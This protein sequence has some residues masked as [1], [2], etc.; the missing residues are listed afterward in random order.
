VTGFTGVLFLLIPGG[1]VFGRGFG[2]VQG[3]LTMFASALLTGGVGPWLPFEMLC[4]AWVGFFAGCLPRAE[5]R[6]EIAMLA[7]YGAVAGL[8]YGLAMDMWFWPYAT[9]GTELHFVA[10]ASIVENLQRFWAFHLASALGFD[11]PRAAG[12]AA[13]VLVA[14]TPVL[15]ALRR[16][17]RRAAF[18]APVTFSSR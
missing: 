16:A 2:F 12:N 1:R 17:A 15:A 13:L 14:G 11:I 10:G 5:G 8:A 4:A 3:A 9:A 6:A 18:G 7:V